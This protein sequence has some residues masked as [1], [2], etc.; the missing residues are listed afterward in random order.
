LRTIVTHSLPEASQSVENGVKTSYAPKSHR[1]LKFQRVGDSARSDRVPLLVVVCHLS[2]T[3]SHFRGIT[4]GNR[5]LQKVGFC[6]GPSPT[7]AGLS[8][9]EETLSAIHLWGSSG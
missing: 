2:Q 5:A 6:A 3:L 1:T 8:L 7:G 4:T 9:L